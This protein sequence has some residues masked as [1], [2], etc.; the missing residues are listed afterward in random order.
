[1]RYLKFSLIFV[2]LLSVPWIVLG[3]NGTIKGNVLD[4]RTGDALPGANVIVQ[5]LS[6]GTATDSRGDFTIERVPIGTRRVEVRFVGYKLMVQE[7]TVSLDQAV[8]VNFQ[9]EEDVLL[10]DEVIVT[11]TAGQARRREIGNSIAVLDITNVQEPLGNV[12]NLLMGRVAGLNVQFGS[13]HPGSGG[14][15]RLRGNNSVAMSNAPLIY[16][17]GVR[18]RADA[19]PKNVPPV[20]FSGRSTGSITSPLNDINPNDV[21][22][23]EIIKGASA[24]TLYGTEAAGGVVQIFT[25]KG[26]IGQPNWSVQIDQGFDRMLEYGT[27]KRPYMGLDPFIDLGYRSKYSVSVGGGGANMR[28]Y[29]S[30]LFNNQ[31]GVLPNSEQ[32]QVQVRGN[33]GFS[34]LENLQ[35]NVTTTFS[36]SDVQNPPGGN[37][38][39]GLTLNA[40]RGRASYFGTDWEDPNFKSE[41][42]Q[43]LEYE[44]TTEIDRLL[45]GAEMIYEPIPNFIHKFN[46]GFDRSAIELRNIR[47]FGFVRARNG[48]LSVENWTG[49]TLTLEYSASYDWRVSPDFRTNLTVGGQKVDNSTVSVLAYGEDVPPGEPT[50]SSAAVQLSRESRQKVV[51]AGFF[52]QALF[53]FKNKYFLTLGLRVDG[54]SA[55]GDDFGLQTYPKVSAAYMI[56]DESFW[57]SNL[58]RVKLRAAWGQAGRA[59]GAFDAVRT[60]NPVGWGGQV[61]FEPENVGNPNLAPERTTEI[62]FGFEAAFMQERLSVDFSW[63]NATTSDALF[64]VEQIPSLGFL[65]SQLENVGEINNRGVELA[66]NATLIEKHNFGLDIGGTLATNFSEVKDL[67]GAAAFTL[68]SAGGGRIQLGDPAPAVVGIKILNPDEFAD[69]VFALDEAG[70]KDT[71]AFYGPNLPTHTIGAFISL[72]LPKGI[73]L[74]ARGEYM[75]GHYIEDTASSNAARRGAF[76]YCDELVIGGRNAYELIAEGNVDGL[77]AFQRAACTTSLA[78]DIFI[79][80]ADFFKL[81]ELTLSVPLNLN[82]QGV[83]NVRFT[84]SGRNIFRWLNDDFLLFDPEMAGRRGGRTGAE[85]DRDGIR[86]IDENIPAPSTWTFSL[87]FQF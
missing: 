83:R 8:T 6:L 73:T 57:P 62:E 15:I 63:Y 82:F 59:P 39:H 74:F 70:N 22:R 55:F 32:Q 36:N 79:Y 19:Y 35:V 23:V 37:N 65:G 81:R 75:A 72:R 54:N 33:F 1:M 50:V 2:F 31:E 60:W 14:L 69:P 29:L 86:Y 84:L 77:T 41:L 44:I 28:Y 26:R 46:V 58:G 34:P 78:R 49:E 48:I 3:Q 5:D 71:R 56:S 18:V 4:A 40:L 85:V 43:L 10:L 38:A 11:G 45:T 76:S 20:G 7:V 42:E 66:V 61:A 30:G 24:T 47:R 51:N 9:L 87:R 64:R 17:D 16:I 25:K 12:D 52:G 13:G 68:P 53:D 27:E 21:E 80:P 67:G